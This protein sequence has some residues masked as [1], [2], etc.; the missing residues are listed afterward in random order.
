MDGIYVGS[1]TDFEALN[2]FLTEH[3]IHPV[4]DRI[5]SCDDAP[6]AYAHLQSGSH[7]GKVVI[8]ADGHD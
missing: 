7:F 4:I 8:L 6:A 2:A 5:F 1:R 3:R